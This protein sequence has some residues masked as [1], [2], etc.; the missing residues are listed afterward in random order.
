MQW[1]KIMHRQFNRG[2]VAPLALLFTLVSMSFT[3]AYLKNSFSQS[4]MEKYRYA[5]WRA[6][7]AAE[8][9]LNDVGIIILPQITSDTLLI[10][11]GV[12]YGKDENDQPV[13]VYKDIACSTRL[14]I[15]STRKEYIAYATG[16]AE[17]TT[18]SG[19]D[20]SIERRV[21]TTMVPQGFEEF[22]YFTH[23]EE[24]IGPGNTG[25]VNFGDGDMLEGK[26]HTNGVMTMS[27]AGCPT[28]TGEVNITFDAIEQNGT[29]INY[30]NCSEEIFEDEDENTI[31]DTVSTIIFPPSNSA[32]VARQSASRVFEADDKLFRSGKKDT[33]IMTEIEFVEGG[34]W[35]TQWWYNIPPVGSP[36][37]EYDFKF[38][39]LRIDPPLEIEG[40][41][42]TGFNNGDPPY[43]PFDPETNTYDFLFLLVSG[44][45]AN[46][47][48]IE[49]EIE[50]VFS[51]EDAPHNVVL[52]NENGTKVLSFTANGV[53]VLSGNRIQITMPPGAPIIYGGPPGV[54]FFDN[55]P[56]KLINT[57]ATQ[58]LAEGVEWNSFHFYHDH[59][60]DGVAYCEPGRIQHFDFE[61]WNYGGISGNECD[62]FT[63]PDVIYN[64]EY[65]HMNR[66]FFSKG[67]SP[68]VIYVKG[69][70]VL[71]RGT[72]DGLYTIVTDDY[73]EYRRHDDN[74]IIDRVWGNIW[75]IDD[76]VYADSDV[77]GA[78][79][80]PMDGGSDN[81]LG[82]IAGGNVIIANTRPN[83]AHSQAFGGGHEGCGYE[84][85]D[86]CNLDKCII[87]NASILAMHGGF[88]SHYW[89]NWLTDYHDWNDGLAYGIIAD[90][91]GGHRNPYRP[92][93][94][95]GSYNNTNDSRG[96]VHL[97]GSIVQYKRGYMNRNYFGPYN[98]TPGVGYLKDYHYDWN[99]QL[100]PPP[101]FPDLESSDNSVILKMASYGE[102]SSIK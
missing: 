24:P 44:L 41:Y 36:P 23:K 99:L 65:V 83:G 31:L 40:G 72:V 86:S 19:T 53:N 89:Q 95:S 57:S 55:E 74:D 39:S 8:A 37:T 70:Q 46:G 59:L 25:V 90:G 30:G 13:G 77:N 71:V 2:S 10:Q 34:Y 9:G 61:Y 76:I 51:A 6:L 66:A 75:L 3:V 56:V 49:N 14:Q 98:V 45:D 102:A 18:P 91:R 100:K 81:V 12:D 93:S 47:I 87:I 15:N 62:I 80:H 42:L 84:N 29:A 1:V 22:M 60:D 20:V 85:H 21:Y 7:Y 11:N 52:Q 63:C 16:V 35:A 96:R 43:D 17:Y 32:E 50:S 94:A 58:G 38:D 78:I 73:T 5:E 54:G 79:V 64:S 27:N 69:G 33:L 68:Q 101:Y 82:L 26:V 97:W 48:N 88:I 4:A 28:F 92:E 67:N